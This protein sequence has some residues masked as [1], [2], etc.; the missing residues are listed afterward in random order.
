MLRAACGCPAAIVTR[1]SGMPKLIAA[2]ACPASCVAIL[3]LM[4]SAREKSFADC[5]F[6]RQRS[7]HCIAAL[8]GGAGQASN[9]PPADPWR[10]PAH[11]ATASSVDL[12][13]WQGRKT[14]ADDHLVDPAERH[15]HSPDTPPPI[16]KSLRWVNDSR[17]PKRSAWV[18]SCS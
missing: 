17:S 2:I 15:P 4:A 3:F 9:G 16:Q 14:R 13:Q 8:R 12:H 6:R 18:F 1:M 7:E 10:S 5:F 11:K